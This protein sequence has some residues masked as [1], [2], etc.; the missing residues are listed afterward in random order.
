MVDDFA[1]LLRGG[2][3]VFLVEDVEFLLFAS[4]HLL[5]DIRVGS[6]EAEDHRLGE[7]VLLVGLDDGSGEVVASKDSTEDVDEDSFDFG[8]GVKKFQGF[9]QLLAFGATADIKEIGGLTS[10]EFDDI[11]S[12]HGK[13]GAVDEAANVTS[14]M[15]VVEVE[16]LGVLFARVILSLVLLSG[17]ILLTEQSVGVDGDLG[18]SSEHLSLLGKNEGVD[19]DEIGIAGHEALVDLGEHVHN[20]V[21]LGVETE[22]F[23]SL[24]ELGIVEALRVRNLELED[25]L[26][27]LLGNFLN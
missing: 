6:L 5:G 12:G 9:C 26:G 17:E 24:A 13:T 18:I 10:V 19:L 3:E 27:L 2:V 22:V 14:D 20:L 16:V 25:F 21:D 15:D 11:H 7:G 4:D 8:I 1:D 23:G